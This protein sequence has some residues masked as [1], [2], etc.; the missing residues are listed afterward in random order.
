MAVGDVRGVLQYV[1]MFRGRTFIVVFDAGL[2]ES[3]VAE[4]LLDSR[5]IDINIVDAGLNKKDASEEDK[6]SRTALMIATA[7]N[8]SE[9]VHCALTS[10]FTL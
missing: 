5:N 1:P 6:K 2:P 7:K 10:F 9:I 8:H 4:A 3:A